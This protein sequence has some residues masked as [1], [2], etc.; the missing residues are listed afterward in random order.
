MILQSEEYADQI[1]RTFKSNFE[2]GDDP[3]DLLQTICMGLN[4]SDGDL[5]PE[6]KRRIENEIKNYLMRY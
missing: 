2:D 1:I 4:I 5:M 3:N 6:S